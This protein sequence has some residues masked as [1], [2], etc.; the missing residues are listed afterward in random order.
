VNSRKLKK[1]EF[2]RVPFGLGPGSKWFI[3]K[4]PE[5]GGAKPNTTEKFVVVF[6]RKMKDYSMPNFSMVMMI[7]IKSITKWKE[8]PCP[9]Y[10][11]DS[12]GLDLIIS[13][14]VY[15]ESESGIAGR[16]WNGIQRWNN[17]VVP[18]W[19]HGWWIPVHSDGQ[20]DHIQLGCVARR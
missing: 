7:G 4:P 2:D 19:G 18:E 8:P 10:P 9:N 13:D 14:C 3:M 17:I 16:V 12:Y 5:E 15:F 20:Q 1:D 11:Q 6:V